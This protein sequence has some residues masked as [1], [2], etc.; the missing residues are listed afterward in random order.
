MG[1][2]LSF[3]YDREADI[4]FL[5]F[6][7]FLQRFANEPRFEAFCKKVGLPLMAVALYL[8]LG[9]MMPI[10]LGGVIRRFTEG[11]ATGKSESNAGVLCASGLIAGEGLAGIAIAGVVALGAVSKDTQT[12]I[13]GSVGDLLALGVTVLVLLMLYNASGAR[14]GKN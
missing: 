8:P 12:L 4:L 7:P 2:K 14:K 13:T 10:F 11:K 3:K 1:A 5:R 6:D 9:S